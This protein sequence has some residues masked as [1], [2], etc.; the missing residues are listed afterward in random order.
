M[1]DELR[2]AERD[3]LF[4]VG[5]RLV[6]FEVVVRPIV[7]PSDLFETAQA[8]LLHLNV[9]VDL[10]VERALLFIELCESERVA[11]DSESLQVEPLDRGEVI[12]IPRREIAGD[13]IDRKSTRLNS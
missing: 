13:E 11:R 1:G 4:Q 6:A 10:V 8:F 7:D 5:H 2:S 12:D 9:E 3:G